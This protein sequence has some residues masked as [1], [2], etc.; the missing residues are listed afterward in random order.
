LPYPEPSRLLQIRTDFPKAPPS[1]GDWVY[2]NDARE[3]AR[4]NH[5]FASVGI[6]GNAVPDLAGDQSN[7]PEAL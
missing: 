4:R 2:P 7:L 5:S 3:I 6:Y 1:H